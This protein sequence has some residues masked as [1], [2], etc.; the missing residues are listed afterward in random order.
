MTH[1]AEADRRFKQNKGNRIH[2]FSSPIWSVTAMILVAGLSLWLVTQI[3]FNEFWFDEASQFWLSQGQHL[4]LDFGTT[5]APLSWQDLHKYNLDPPGFSGLLFLWTE[6]IPVNPQTLRLLPLVFTAG[7]LVAMVYFSSRFF[8]LPLVFGVALAL[9]AVLATPLR[10]LATELRPYS[11]EF[12]A[13]IVT[14]LALANYSRNPASKVSS[15]FIVLLPAIFLFTTRYSYVIAAISVAVALTFTA[16]RL[17]TRQAVT[18]AVLSTIVA[19]IGVVF[20][21]V[22]RASVVASDD[23]V[24][25]VSSFVLRDIG[26]SQGMTRALFVNLV[27]GPQ[28]SFVGLGVIF[29]AGLLVRQ[30]S[31][32]ERFGF[33]VTW[34]NGLSKDD[35]FQSLATFIFTYLLGA[36]S[37]SAIGLY[38]WYLSQ[39]WSIGYVAVTYIASILMLSV[40]LSILTA[41][42]ATSKGIEQFPASRAQPRLLRVGVAGVI[43]ALVVYSL[44]FYLT[45][46]TR[47]NDLLIT[48]T[49]TVE[50]LAQLREEAKTERAHWVIDQLF[51]PSVRMSAQLGGLEDELTKTD[52]FVSTG[53]FNLSDIAVSQFLATEYMCNA[54]T[55]LILIL[56]GATDGWKTTL[57]ELKVLA[58][59]TDCEIGVFLS[60]RTT[61]AVI[62]PTNLLVN[63]SDAGL[64]DTST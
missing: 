22:T 36:I 33:I 52:S 31:N 32:D 20:I 21:W 5:K 7:A 28:I 13:V 61:L 2:S 49:G 46:P 60:D 55:S 58:R 14:A 43:P 47:E 42:D 9:S 57:G 51:W 56:P 29:L 17:R 6:I 59:T 19:M 44:V 45:Q 11:L 23:S 62:Q 54:S 15:T 8:S 37:L 3:R 35:A 18:S 27:A 50:T 40:L 64:G 1:K 10:N 41:D 34:T 48:G 12:F 39:K 63:G 53:E 24:S 38:P 16:W 26:V 30:R 25:Y 4:Y